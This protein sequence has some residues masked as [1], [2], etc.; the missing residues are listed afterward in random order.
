MSE[1]LTSRLREK[2]SDLLE[3]GVVDVII[4][5][6]LGTLPLRSTP[7]FAFDANET[8]DFI[9]DATCNNN[10]AVYLQDFSGKKVGLIAKGCDARSAIMLAIEKQFPREDLILIGVSC[11]KMI[12]HARIRS[13]F[14][15]RVRSARIQG[16]GLMLTVDG[17]ERKFPISEFIAEDCLACAHRQLDLCDVMIGEEIRAEKTRTASY[18]LEEIQSLAPGKRWEWFSRKFSRCN[19]CYACRE[20]CPACYCELCF[21]DREM[22]RWSEKSKDISDVIAFHLVRALHLAGRC[23][24]CG[25]CERACPQGINLRALTE[26]AMRVEEER[27]GAEPGIDPQ[28]VP[29]LSTYSE[30]DPGDFIL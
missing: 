26:K 1:D 10:L 21:V 14:G 17:E 11:P 25:A 16:E 9:F 15:D 6:H 3:T 30:K 18:L 24:G 19:L 13:R 12:D 4:G 7:H 20:T 5:Y 2:A 22:P 28:E 23:V 27:F 8:D 29:A